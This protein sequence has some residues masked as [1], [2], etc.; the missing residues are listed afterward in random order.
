MEIPPI[1][2]A[3]ERVLSKTLGRDVRLDDVACI[4]DDGRRNLLLRARDSSGS[5][6]ASFIIKKVVADAFDP[7]D[8]T[9]FDTRRFF[10][11][12]AG[13]EFLSTALPVPRTPRFYGGDD[14]Q[15]FFILEDMGPHH[16]LVEPLL[17]EDAG[18]AERALLGLS[19][20]LGSVHAAT[21]GESEVFEKLLSRANPHAGTLSRAITGF[22]ERVAQLQAST[23]RLGVRAVVGLPQEIDAVLAAI[24]NPGLFLSY[25]HGDPCPD[26]VFWDGDTLRLIDFEFGGLGHALIDAAYGRMLFPSCWCANRLPATVVTKM[27]AAYRAELVNGCPQA[28]EDRI[29]EAALATVCAFW[30]LN[31]LS[32]QLPNALEADRTWGIATVR[33]RLLARL[34]AFITTSEEFHH[35]PALRGLASELREVLHKAWPGTPS[36]PLYPAFQRA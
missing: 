23:E 17:G 21:I 19:A 11:D 16:S 34:D 33:Q 1:V 10:N 29:F 13:A 14:A 32:R 36:L 24:D 20:C 3:A 35:L 18:S 5:S 9:A 31:T 8:A 2:A 12:W 4:S 6:P 28:Q 26:N 30:L 7:A 15:G 22:D 27:E 25:I